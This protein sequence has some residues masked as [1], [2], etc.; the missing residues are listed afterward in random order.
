MERDPFFDLFRSY[1]FAISEAK[2]RVSHQEDCQLQKKGMGFLEGQTFKK[3]NEPGNEKRVRREQKRRITALLKAIRDLDSAN[4]IIDVAAQ[5]NE[6]LEYNYPSHGPIK[7]HHLTSSCEAILADISDG[8][9]K[10]RSKN[11]AIEVAL[12]CFISYR[13]ANNLSVSAFMNAGEPNDTVRA[14]EA[15]LQE[16]DIRVG[17]EAIAQRL[18]RLGKVRNG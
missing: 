8:T 11:M 14:A 6:K 18:K 15:F 2:R 1:E 9:R 17:C 5:I 16:V 13:I 4:D 12:E 3:L 7:W 10:G